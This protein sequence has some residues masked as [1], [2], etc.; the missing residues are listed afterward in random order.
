MQGW[1]VPALYFHAKTKIINMLI[2]ILY[3]FLQGAKILWDF[4]HTFYGLPTDMMCMTDVH[5]ENLYSSKQIQHL[6]NFTKFDLVNQQ[7][8]ADAN[9]SSYKNTLCLVKSNHSVLSSD[10]YKH[11]GK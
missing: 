6:L 11:R 8:S 3:L 7:Q 4:G 10:E 5:C 2:R 9:I 1:F